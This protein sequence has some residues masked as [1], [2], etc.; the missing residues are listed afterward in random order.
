[1]KGFRTSH[2]LILAVTL[3]GL[4]ASFVPAAWADQ[5]PAAP[6]KVTAIEGITEYRLDNGLRI[7]LFPDPS[8][9]T[10][11][12]NMTVMVGSRHEGYGETGMAHLLEH[13]LFKG[14]PTHQDIPKALRDH[15]AQFNGTTWLDRTNYFET[16]PANDEN[17][18]FAI[19]LEADRLVNSLIRR[20]D[21]ASEM[22]VVRSEFE[23]GEN[24][25]EYVLSQRMMA[26]AF[27]WHNYGKATIGNRSDIERVPVDNLRAF[28]KKYYQPNNT[29]LIVAGNFKPD[30]A[31]QLISR[32]FGPIPKPKERLQPTYT[33]EPAQDGE[34]TVILRRVGK[35][36]LVGA[37]YHIPAGAHEDFPAVQV[38][39]HVL[40]S[41]PSGR[42]YTALVPDKKATQ[43]SGAAYSLHDPGIIEFTVQI[44]PDKIDTI[45]AVRDAMLD[46]LEKFN[47]KP[48]TDEEV[49]RA[50]RSILKSRELL[51]ARSNRI[52]IELSEW[53]AKGDWR[54]FFL[55]R[56]RLEQVTPA[57][58]ARVAGKYLARSNRTVG[59]FIPTEKPERSPVPPPPDVAE[60]V[61]DYQGREA[62]AAGEEF[63]PTPENI[64]KRTRRSELPC[65][66]QVAV[67]PKKTRGEIVTLRLTL[68]FGNEKSLQGQ[69]TA[70]QFLGPLMTRGTKQHTR[71]QLQDELDKLK[72][73][74]GGS[75]DLGSVTFSI[76]TKRENLPQVLA[77]LNEVLR[78]PTFPA[79]EF[80]VLKR[81]MNDSIAQGLTEPTTLA[82]QELRRRLSPYDPD[83]IRYV[84]TMAESL[85]QLNDV[86]ID[87]VRQLYYEQL[88]GQV[89]EL[90]IVGDFNVEPTLNQLQ[91]ILN[92]WTTKVPYE[93]IARP[94]Q[95]DV[96]GDK[97]DIV[98]PDKENSIYI[99]AH[100]LALTDDDPAY[101]PLRIA[102]Y[103]FGEG[104]LSSRLGNRVR[105]KEGLSYGVRSA[106]TAD[107]KDKSAR[108]LMYAI[109]NPTNIDKVDHA[110]LDELHKLL[111]EG[112]DD[113]ELAEA[114][115]AYL[116]QLKVGRSSDA[117]LAGL[118][119][120][121]LEEGRTLAFQA[122]LEKKI[123]DLTP[124]QVTE[125]VRHH[126]QPKK[127]VI[128]RAGDFK[129]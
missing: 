32:Y 38:L 108:F 92:G 31:L 111:K 11:T 22:T 49:E 9:S 96:K 103:L 86:T 13:M 94:A 28:Y 118:L 116:A 122:D 39:N 25:P 18:E 91:E 30:K 121:S 89:G 43:V 106:F 70:A 53:Q 76:E 27:E 20:E 17:L 105:Q 5:A 54:L 7:L 48:P 19:R 23:Q 47:D 55:H 84:P 40:V 85:K 65:G 101:V 82:I 57:D 80:D 34:R 81:E 66:V 123:A 128:I 41:E 14:T 98:T 56:D 10:V 102:S 24:S 73:R 104:A 129:K 35:V 62:V 71:Q 126:F 79:D 12:V 95:V 78:S 4:W 110:M 63:D 68:R 3:M 72:A 88:G 100:A 87:Q 69:N 60:L 29:M 15:G 107:A 1:M 36:G 75:S 113:T 61:K 59:M 124:A 44:A 115:K 33:E 127:L 83:D 120:T 52:G 114:K 67:L 77:L 26:V 58:V 2:R 46:V 64:E 109:C 74:L 117:A 90:V 6:Q 97:L 50:K 119:A 45:E 93:R 51:M 99:A 112:V 16:L 42:L 37:L 125:A 8:T 21:L